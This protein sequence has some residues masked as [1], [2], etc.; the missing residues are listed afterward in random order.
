MAALRSVAVVATGDS[1]SFAVYVLDRAGQLRHFNCVRQQGR[2][3][4]DFSWTVAAR[5]P[6]RRWITWV[7]GRCR[8]VTGWRTLGTSAAS[9]LTAHSCL[10]APSRAPCSRGTA[11]RPR[12]APDVGKRARRPAHAC[13]CRVSGWRWPTSTH[14][15]AALGLA[16][17]VAART[18]CG[19]VG[20]WRAQSTGGRV[21]AAVGFDK[22]SVRR[23]HPSPSI[24][25]LHRS[26]HITCLRFCGMATLG[27]KKY[28]YRRCAQPAELGA[29]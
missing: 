26:L 27:R 20:K 16:L 19:C 13:A 21:V 5:S 24:R 15:S 7:P 8:P 10:A 28:C 11:A 25:P 18:A 17:Y 4:H 6:R 2:D 12:S 9:P 23:T 1:G 3:A 29:L 14:G 22:V